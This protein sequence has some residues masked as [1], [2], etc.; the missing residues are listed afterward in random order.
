MKESEFAVQLFKSILVA[1]VCCYT[2]YADTGSAEDRYAQNSVVHTNTPKRVNQVDLAVKLEAGLAEIRTLA[3]RGEYTQALR[4]INRLIE[5]APGIPHPI[6]VKATLLEAVGKPGEAAELY[7]RLTISHPELAEPFN[8]L[9]V[10]YIHSGDYESAI[11]TLETAFEGHRGYATVFKN[12]QS[13]YDR[14]ASNAYRKALD[15]EKPADALELVSLDHIPQQ[16]LPS[17]TNLPHFSL[18]AQDSTENTGTETAAAANMNEIV[19]LPVP[20]DADFRKTDKTP[21]GEIEENF[22]NLSDTRSGDVQQV[23][24][25]LND[26]TIH[27]AEM[28]QLSPPPRNAVSPLGQVTAEYKS[29]PGDSESVLSGHQE[30]NETIRNRIESWA[31][32][33][34]KRDLDRYLSY[35]SSEFIPRYNL[36]LEQWKKHQHALW[37]WR[38]LIV[39]ELS[40]VSIDVSGNDA[41]VK[42]TQYYKSN[43]SSVKPWN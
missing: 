40:D 8:N 27:T 33:W 37:R 24:S 16:L 12:L 17:F 5:S 38:K 29:L 14:L 35:Y 3:S 6:F 7:K 10:H 11:S 2:F 19:V 4:D 43:S 1:A 13:I 28:D 20:A 9:A 39:V 41:I 22:Q 30:E 15:I 31:D 21:G 26:R 42:F 36:T 25:R 23:D 34:S 32:A 18:T